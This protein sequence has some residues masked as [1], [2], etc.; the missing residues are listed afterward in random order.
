MKDLLV[1]LMIIGLSFNL[2]AQGF[3]ITG[4]QEAYKGTIGEVIKAPLNF[5]NNSNRAITLIIRKASSQIG[6][7][8]KTYFCQDGI[9]LDQKVDDMIVRLEPGQTLNNLHVAL[10]AGLVPGVSSLKFIAYNRSNPGEALELDFNFSVEEKPEKESIYSSRHISLKDVYPNPTVDYAYVEY[11]IL[12]DQV[13]AKIIL[14]N[15]LGNSVGEYELSLME[16]R[17]K[18]STADLNAGIYFYTLYLDGEAVMT[19]KL[20]VKK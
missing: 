6:T 4:M 3:E 18:I 1:L 17:A 12:Q 10:E 20:I 7:S 9:C 15:V 16:S 14:H 5:R 19:R 2:A 8:Q 13:K 11:S